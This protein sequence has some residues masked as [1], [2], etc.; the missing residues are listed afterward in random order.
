ML[1]PL[2]IHIMQIRTFFIGVDSSLEDQENFNKFLRSHRII[3]VRQ[4]YDETRG[5]WTFAVNY[6]D[7]Q[8]DASSSNFVSRP[9]KVDYR[10]TLTPE[11][12]EVFSRLREVRK[13][14]AKDESVPAY[15]IFT[16]KE[17]S[18][19]ASLPDL[20]S[21]TMMKIEGINKGRMDRYG[22]SMLKILSTMNS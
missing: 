6:L 7:S 10:A 13:Q 3:E 1:H 21:D 16:D 12:F 14:M 2:A 8:T 22:L 5:L 11:V 20:N 17:L 19:I 15:A 18:L 4:Q 9:D